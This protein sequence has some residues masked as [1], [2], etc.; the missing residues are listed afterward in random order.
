VISGQ[1]FV[2]QL[3]SRLKAKILSDRWSRSTDYR[4]GLARPGCSGTR[5]CGV[6]GWD[7]SRWG[8]HADSAM[9]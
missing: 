8:N 6:N 5:R 4:S 2:I 3:T 1:L 9:D 7:S